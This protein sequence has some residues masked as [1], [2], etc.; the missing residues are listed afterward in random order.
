MT[1]ECARTHPSRKNK[2]AARVGHPEFHL[3]WVGNAGGGLKRISTLRYC[4]IQVDLT[5]GFTSDPRFLALSW[6]R[7]ERDRRAERL[8]KRP[9]IEG[10]T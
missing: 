10:R 4:R 3:P 9:E 1:A 6:S 5:D 7:E 2:N 8:G